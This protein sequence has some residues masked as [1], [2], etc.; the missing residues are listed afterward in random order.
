MLDSDSTPSREAQQAG[1]Q[2]DRGQPRERLIDAA[3][4][5][6]GQG[7]YATTTVAQISRRARVSSATFYTLFRDKEQCLLAAHRRAAEALLKRISEQGAVDQK[8]GGARVSAFEP[9]FELATREPDVLSLLFDEV[10]LATRS[11][12]Q[13]RDALISE[14]EVLIERGRGVARHASASELPARVVLGAALRLLVR[15]ASDPEANLG[16]LRDGLDGWLR[17]Y[18]RSGEAPWQTLTPVPDLKA[19][20]A[21]IVTLSAPQ[22]PGRGRSNRSREQS[23][24]NQ[25]ERILHATAAVCA[26][27]GYAATSVADVVAAAGVAREVFYTHFRDKQ[28][29]FM[30]AYETGFQGLMSATVAAFFT[31]APWPERVWSALRAYTDFMANYPTFAYLGMVE[32][33]AVS[34]ELIDLVDERVMA[35]TLFLEEGQRPPYRTDPLPDVVPEAIAMAIYEVTSHMLRHARGEEIPGLVPLIAYV[36][37]SPYLGATEA[38][39]FVETRLRADGVP[40]A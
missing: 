40:G 17:Y 18:E 39:R 9:I 5:L 27:Q 33:H 10:T 28:D 21:T 3:A 19:G 31:S 4:E 34:Q 6:I 13:A 12:L 8:R 15:R 29:A 35:F 22:R 24:A 32:S 7:T 38:T 23:A 16:E 36:V 37:L 1:H 14:I 30:T 2:L 11:G 25:R 26:E 20:P